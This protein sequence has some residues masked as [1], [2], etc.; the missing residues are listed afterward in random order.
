MANRNILN[1]NWVKITGV[2]STIFMLIAGGYAAGIY[3]G[4]LDC[5]LDKFEMI[6]A[7]QEKLEEIKSKQ[8][9]SKIQE[10]EQKSKEFDQVLKLFKKKLDE[11]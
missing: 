4:N 11:K 9:D 7:Y 5:K 6:T 10:F 2:V 3:E 1:Q 8:Q